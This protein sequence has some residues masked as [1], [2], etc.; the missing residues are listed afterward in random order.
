MCIQTYMEE[1]KWI[2]MNSTYFW[3]TI[4][5]TFFSD[6]LFSW[7]NV[8]TVGAANGCN[9]ESDIE[10]TPGPLGGG[11]PSYD[12]SSELNDWNRYETTCRCWRITPAATSKT[13]NLQKF[14]HP[15]LL[16]W[17]S[18]LIPTWRSIITNSHCSLASLYPN[19]PCTTATCKPKW[20]RSSLMCGEKTTSALC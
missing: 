5:S 12:V 3:I 14:L 18:Y 4:N 9:S 17:F 6:F 19:P 13:L 10:M 7:A 2:K 11:L 8:V 16:L 20:T 1:Y 15:R